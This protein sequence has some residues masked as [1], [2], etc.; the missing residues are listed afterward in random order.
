MQPTFRCTKCSSAA[1]RENGTSKG[2][3][4]YLCTA[5]R[6]QAVFAASGPTQSGAVRPDGKAAGAGVATGHCAPDGRSADDGS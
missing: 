6:H 4:K 2:K 3:S 5:C 1:L